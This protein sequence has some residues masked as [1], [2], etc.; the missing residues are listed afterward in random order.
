MVPITS[1]N[2]EQ[3]VSQIQIHSTMGDVDPPKFQRE[4][5]PKEVFYEEESDQEALS[6]QH[7]PTR[8]EVQVPEQII[9]QIEFTHDSPLK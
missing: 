6:K 8:M 5:T 4:F 1:T 2:N 9:D 7:H 3:I